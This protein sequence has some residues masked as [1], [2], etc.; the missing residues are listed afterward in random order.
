M[1]Y[2]Y[3]IGDRVVHLFSDC[4][5]FL[6]AMYGD[7]YRN[8]HR[9][10]SRRVDQGKQS[11]RGSTLNSY[12]GLANY[13]NNTTNVLL[14]ESTM[15]FHNEICTS[16]HNDVGI[17]SLSHGVRTD[18]QN[19]EYGTPDSAKPEEEQTFYYC[20]CISEPNDSLSLSLLQACRQIHEEAASVPYE[21]NTFIFQDIET[22]SAFLGLF[23]PRDND[24][25]DDPTF[26]FLRSSA[27]CRM[28]HVRLLSDDAVPHGSLFLTGL[29][30][31]GLTLLT[32]LYTFELTLGV[33][34]F[35]WPT[36]W[37]VHDSFFGL[38]RSVEKVVINIRGFTETEMEFWYSSDLAPIKAVRE[39][40]EKLMEQI[41]K[42]DGFRNETVRH[43]LEIETDDEAQ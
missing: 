27:I 23:H 24:V 37:E 22:F 5:I 20:P 33:K 8:L 21:S 14:C 12:H 41:L 30:R 3:A 15:R 6:D 28:R 34:L 13:H 43:R 31:A 1:I 32:G 26:V 16:R 36:E 10:P 29:L 35:L 19:I 17:L 4:P 18:R 25:N 40:A 38:S 9:R 7:S 11:E 42:K 2:H 39:F